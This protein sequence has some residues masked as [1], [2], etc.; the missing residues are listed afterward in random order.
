MSLVFRHIVRKDRCRGQR[1]R[2]ARFHAAFFG[3]QFHKVT[4]SG[5]TSPALATHARTRLI[6]SLHDRGDAVAASR[7]SCGMA[8][9][10]RTAIPNPRP[11]ARN[12][13]LATL[14][15]P[16]ATAKRV[17]VEEDVHEKAGGQF[18]LCPCTIQAARAASALSAPIAAEGRA[19][20]SRR[21][22]PCR[23]PARPAVRHLLRRGVL[24]SRKQHTGFPLIYEQKALLPA[25]L[26][27]TR[28]SQSPNVTV[29]HSK[30]TAKDSEE[31]L[32][33]RRTTSL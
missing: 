17:A 13:G 1:E 27:I 31:K 8:F 2:R 29:K 22:D 26:Q 6:P 12:A 28:S 24:A 9:Q 7:Q 5:R 32:W 16:P 21:A 15:A 18:Y 14:A 23:A 20:G 30:N 3:K 19:A 4:I 11:Q 25:L 10:A 33:H